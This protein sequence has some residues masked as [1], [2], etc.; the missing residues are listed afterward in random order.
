MLN[1]EIPL[2]TTSTDHYAVPIT[3][4]RSILEQENSKIVLYTTR[5][6]LN[7]KDIGI[8]LHRQFA[9]PPA[10][11]LIKLLSNS[12]YSHDQELKQIIKDVS[13]SC[14]VCKRYKRQPRRPVVGMPLATRFNHTVAM[15]LKFIRGIIIIHVI[16]SFTRFSAA[17][18]LPSKEPKGIITFLFTHWINIFGPPKQFLTDNGGEFVNKEFDSMCE[19]FNVTVKR[20]AAESPWSNGICERYNQVL[21]EMVNKILEDVNCSMSVAVSWAVCAKNS[22]S[23]MHGFS[24]A[25]LVFGYTPMLPCVQQDKPP[26]LTEESYAKYIEEHLQAMRKSRSAFIHSESSQRIKRALAHNLRS[27]ND[28]K[29]LSGDSVYFKRENEARW[30]GPAHVVGQDGQYVLVKT[31]S[32][33]IRVHPSKLILAK[34]DQ[35]DDNYFDESNK[36]KSKHKKGPDSILDPANSISISDPENSTDEDSEVPSFSEETHQ[37]PVEP[38]NIEE[39]S[40]IHTLSEDT[41]PDIMNNKK[42]DT[43]ETKKKEKSKA[44]KSGMKIAVKFNG[45]QSWTYATI[46]SRSGK[47]KGKY[48]NEYNVEIDN[49]IQQINLDTEVSELKVVENTLKPISEE[50]KDTEK[51]SNGSPSE[52]DEIIGPNTESAERNE[53]RELAIQSDAESTE[54]EEIYLSRVF[55]TQ[56]NGEVLKAKEKEL[57]DWKDRR[58]YTEIENKGQ[59]CVSVKWLI[60]PKLVNGNLKTKGRLVAR[61][62]EEKAEIRRDSPACSKSGVRL[63]LMIIATNNW[64][65]KSMDVQRAFLQTEDIE[66]EVI[67]KPPKEAET[68][69]L[70]LLNRP[71]YGLK[72]ASRRWFLKVRTEMATLGCEW[73]YLEP[74]IFFW[75]IENQ[76]QGI[77]TCFVDDMMYGGTIEFE[78]QVIKNISK[79]IDIGS[80]EEEHFMYIGFNLS[81]ESN[82]TIIVDQFEY[83]DKLQEIPCIS[84]H[85]KQYNAKQEIS[86]QEKTAMRSA[87]GKLNWLATVTRPDISY[88]VCQLSSTIHCATQKDLVKLNKVIKEVKHNPI[89]VKVPVFSST[90]DIELVVFADAAF[91]N[92]SDKGSQGGYIIF[93][94]DNLNSSYP[95]DWSSHKLKRISRSTLTAETQALLDAVNAAVYFSKLISVITNT[96]PKITCYTDSK[97]LVENCKTSH[98]VDEKR[99]LIELACIRESIDKGEVI[100]KWIDTKS[101][102]ADALTKDGVNTGLLKDIIGSGKLMY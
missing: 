14:V 85:S 99:L 59:K 45:Q 102:L 10:E 56:I 57:K 90:S 53:N 25:Q 24:P 50:A 34:T 77:L 71:V 32:S 80:H 82:G 15:D 27:S 2:I 30:H 23:N 36:E 76:I 62:F 31:Q 6:E 78:N 1:E 5:P 73:S 51:A 43:T 97:S 47:A 42:E 58:V 79:S 83:T 26:A 60:K 19:A 18:V 93:V 38:Q 28:E 74:S 96:I 69:K 44:F 40:D 54:S 3:R 39:S 9:H 75:K 89:S 92:L 46:V 52:A 4:N 87:V 29:Y 37:Q 86:E 66:R 8:K 91:A 72:D 12:P 35:V 11:R 63:A 98:V 70:W 55:F 64:K 67:I 94:T 65:L 48:A 49:E 101:Q 33:W 81:Q 21:E 41:E 100:L 20:T 95:L 22:L 61:G 68:L 17:G 7:K 13:E 84:S 88:Y 16:D